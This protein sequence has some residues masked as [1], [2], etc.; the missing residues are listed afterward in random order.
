[1]FNFRVLT[2]T[3]LWIY[4]IFSTYPTINTN[5]FFFTLPSFFIILYSIRK[6]K[7]IFFTLKDMFWFLNLLFFVIA[8]CQMV[9]DSGFVDSVA[10][11]SYLHAYSLSEIFRAHVIVYI[12]LGILSLSNNETITPSLKILKISQ[13]KVFILV[14]IFFIFELASRGN[15]NFI[16]ECRNCKIKTYDPLKMLISSLKAGIYSIG[17]YLLCI[18]SL[19]KKK[20]LAF[21]CLTF[22]LLFFNPLNQAR[23]VFFQFWG[24]VLFIYFRRI[25]A[26]H[27]YV[28]FFISLVVLLPIISKVSRFEDNRYN[29]IFNSKFESKIKDADTFITLI[30]YV[31]FEDKKSSS[32]GRTLLSTLFFFIP[33][34]FWEEKI[35]FSNRPVSENLYEY[36][37][38]TWNLSLF[39]G[40]DFYRDFR[41]I[42]VFVG[43]LLISF[44]RK[45]QKKYSVTYQNVNLSDLLFMCS[46]PILIRGSLIGV[47]GPF[48]ANNFI[49]YLYYYFSKPNYTNRIVQSM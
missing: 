23:F 18:Y 13:K 27:F 8:P 34:K 24:P 21:I 2:Y 45:F 26:L 19:N 47:I 25:K 30:H 15:F 20:T 43:F 17:T 41:F 35:E 4:G 6:I 3:A 32:L 29:E 46:L 10:G 31:H 33:S 38:G 42:G 40:G 5:S 7:D 16:S 28:I 12:Y 37:S 36:G 14:L 9:L 49:L 22:L 48:I 1:M 39:I 11:N 44:L